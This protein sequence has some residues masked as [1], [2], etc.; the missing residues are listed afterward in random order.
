MMHEKKFF[1]APKKNFYAP[2]KNFFRYRK[3]NRYGKKISRIQRSEKNKQATT[4][5]RY[6][7]P[8]KHN[9]TITQTRS[10]W[11]MVFTCW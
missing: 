9:K 10:I 5:L 4:Q 1:Y 3:K 11:I 2:K 7:S 8:P 6:C